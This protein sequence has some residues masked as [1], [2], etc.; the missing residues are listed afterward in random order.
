MQSFLVKGAEASANRYSFKVS[1]SSWM[2]HT[3]NAEHPGFAKT[4]EIC[5]SKPEISIV[6]VNKIESL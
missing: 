3:H 2:S 6:H 5:T 1:E 4:C